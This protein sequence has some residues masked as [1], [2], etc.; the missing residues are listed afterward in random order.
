MDHQEA[1]RIEAVERYLLQELSPEQCA[2]FEEHFFDC[3]ECAVDLRATAAFLH[4]VKELKSIPARAPRARSA[5]PGPH[6]G[7][8]WWIAMAAILVLAVA[9]LAYQNLVLY[10]RLRGEIAKLTEP[11]I[12]GLRPVIRG[13]SRDAGPP[14]TV[15]AT[16][17]ENRLL[18]PIEIPQSR[19]FPAYECVLIGPGASGK[20]LWRASVSADEAKHI[21]YVA[22]PVNF[23]RTGKAYTLL[24]R[25]QP[26]DA[27]EPIDLIQHRF[28]FGISK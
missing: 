12:V 22:I 14:E 8:R 10:P 20:A 1:T 2:E 15:T 28:L 26:Q 13:I 27:P 9:P 18:F 21:V 4:S 5:V 7:A 19:P 24:V 23:L 25:G 11:S 16:A 17:R 3:H 6:W